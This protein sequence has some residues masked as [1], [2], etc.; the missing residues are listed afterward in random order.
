MHTLRTRIDEEI[1]YFGPPDI[2][3]E[4]IKMWCRFCEANVETERK[5]VGIGRYEYHGAK[6]VHI[7]M[8]DICA[9]CGYDRLEGARTEEEMES[10]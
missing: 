3:P 4:P 5:D 2:D 8:Q 1:A 6:G 7:D 9:V 10:E